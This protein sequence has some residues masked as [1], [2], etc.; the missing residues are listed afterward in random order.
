M[1]RG[2]H[3]PSRTVVSILTEAEKSLWSAWENARSFAHHGDIGTAREEAVRQLLRVRLP[4]AYAVDTGEVIDHRDA[5]SSQLDVVIYDKVR[6][7][8][9]IQY[10]LLLP[11]EALLAVVEVKS[12]LTQDELLNCC[13]AAAVHNLRPYKRKFI[14]PPADRDSAGAA[15]PRCFITV[16][17]YDS[18]L[19]QEGW[20]Q[21]EWTRAVTASKDVGCSVNLIDR[22]VVLSRGLISPAWSRGKQ[23]CGETGVAVLYEWFLHLVNFLS[24]ENARRVK[25]TGRHTRLEAVVD[26]FP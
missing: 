2:G 22:I 16:F 13:T 15:D 25:P 1:P 21:K 24:R 26:G 19:S 9:L 3:E 8:P 7:C 6:N 18:N 23:S 10:P 4:G 12:T 11:A 5:H 20:L 14:P 17:A